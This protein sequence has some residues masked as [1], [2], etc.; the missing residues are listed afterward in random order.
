[1]F[2]QDHTP[3]HNAAWRGNTDVV[4]TLLEAGAEIDVKDRVS[5]CMM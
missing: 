2:L 3:L 5:Y 1:M 4:K